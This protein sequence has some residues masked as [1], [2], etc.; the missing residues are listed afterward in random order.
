MV[1]KTSEKKNL[2]TIVGLME[3]IDIALVEG[4]KL[5]G[6]SKIEV[7][8]RDKGT[9]VIS[10]AEE[11]VAVVTDVTEGSFSVPTFD[12]GDYEKIADFIVTHF[13]KKSM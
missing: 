8:R 7:V 11:L 12:L 3:D 5:T 13:I 1:Q 4:F 9:H 10:S 2:D 6:K